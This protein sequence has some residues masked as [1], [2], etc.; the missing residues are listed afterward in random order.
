MIRVTLFG[1]ARGQVWKLVKNPPNKAAGGEAG[2][3]FAIIHDRELQDAVGDRES[4]V[5]G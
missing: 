1:T 2:G 5:V 3:H 4:R